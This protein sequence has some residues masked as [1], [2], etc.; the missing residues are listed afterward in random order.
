MEMKKD[1]ISRAIWRYLDLNRKKDG[2]VRGINILNSG[3]CIAPY[4]DY[5]LTRKDKY[6]GSIDKLWNIVNKM[7]E[8]TLIA[9]VEGKQMFRT[10]NSPGKI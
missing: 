10:R 8:D 2:D 9:E 5:L 7:K 4:I 6:T 3:V 1:G